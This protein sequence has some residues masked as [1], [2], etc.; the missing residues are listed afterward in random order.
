[1]E[2]LL[3]FKRPGDTEWSPPV[4]LIAP[5]SR[6]LVDPYLAPATP[7]PEPVKAA[8]EVRLSAG[9]PP[10]GFSDQWEEFLVSGTTYSFTTITP[11]L[12]LRS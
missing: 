2:V 6:T 5:D 3:R 1:M 8:L 9:C 10:E 7:L 4:A 11:Q 12:R